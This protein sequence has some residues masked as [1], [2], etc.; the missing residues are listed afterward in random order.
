MYISLLPNISELGYNL[1]NRRRSIR[2]AGIVGGASVVE[3]RDHLL[4]HG[5]LSEKH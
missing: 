4:C 3:S 5:L 2:M 1:L